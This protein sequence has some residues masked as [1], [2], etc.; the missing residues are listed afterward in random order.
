ML[1]AQA[2]AT[3]YALVAMLANELEQDRQA[4][5]NAMAA[6]CDRSIAEL[7]QLIIDY[8]ESKHTWLRLIERWQEIKQK[9]GHSSSQD[10]LDAQYAR[11]ACTPN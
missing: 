5:G 6:Y 3:G 1:D 2:H 7:N 4:K 11:L 8:P 10:L 9:H